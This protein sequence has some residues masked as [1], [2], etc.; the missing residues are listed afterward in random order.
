MRDR[1]IVTEPNKFRPSKQQN[2]LLADRSIYSDDVSPRPLTSVAALA[3]LPRLPLL[4]IDR[5]TRATLRTSF[6][7]KG[8]GHKLTSSVPEP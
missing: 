3:S 4:R 2:V 1:N 8:Q 7:V 5:A 6:K